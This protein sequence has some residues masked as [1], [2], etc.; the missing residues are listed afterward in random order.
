M[1]TLGELLNQVMWCKQVFASIYLSIIVNAILGFSALHHAG[2]R[3]FGTRWLFD[4]GS[5]LWSLGYAMEFRQP[6]LKVKLFG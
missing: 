5:I 3:A 1:V 2:Q 6:D 4:L